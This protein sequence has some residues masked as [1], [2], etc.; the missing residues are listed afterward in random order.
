MHACICSARHIFI[1]KY[2]C[3]YVCIRM[4]VCMYIRMQA[5]ASTRL[6]A[7]QQGLKSAAYHW[8]VTWYLA[9]KGTEKRPGGNFR[10][11]M[12]SCRG[13][14]RPPPALQRYLDA[15][16]LLP[17]LF[18]AHVARSL[19]QRPL[20]L[21]LLA[22][23]CMYVCVYVCVYVCTKKPLALCPLLACLPQKLTLVFTA[24]IAGDCYYAEENIDVANRYSRSLSIIV[25][26]FLVIDTPRHPSA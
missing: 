21:E 2:V 9:T 10:G 7:A 22:N 18:P 16:A 20:H 6:H 8:Y 26:L 19:C 5:R 11:Q 4:Y 17:K 23:C 25:G 13:Q 12:P 24:N 3:M 1:Y 15:R 14:D